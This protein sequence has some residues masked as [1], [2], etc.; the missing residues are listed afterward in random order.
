M[1]RIALTLLCLSSIR[2]LH[3][4]HPTVTQRFGSACSVDAVFRARS[5]TT[6]RLFADTEDKAASSATS[7]APVL[8]GKRVLPYKVLMAGLKGNSDVA[9]VFALMNKD[10]K[11]G[12]AGWE[13][14][15]HVGV[16]IDFE[17]DLTQLAEEFGPE[18]F[19]HV[20]ALSFMFP[21]EGAMQSIADDWRR[22][23]IKAGGK[24]NVDPVSAAMEMPYDVNDDDD[25]E[26][27]EDD[28]DFM[29]MT[30]EAMAMATGGGVAQSEKAGDG[31]VSPFEMPEAASVS[32]MAEEKVP[33][34]KENVDK[35]LDEVRPYLISDGGNVSVERVDEATR[36]VYL[37]L[38]GA[39]GSCPSS[40][41]TMQ[42]G[43]E[44]VLKEKFENLGEVLRV[45]DDK[46]KELSFEMV[47]AEVNRIS[48]AIMAMGGTVEIV[49]VDGT[50]GIVE[51]KFSG[52]SK[53][54]QGLE[55]AI[56]D[57]DFVTEVK[58][59]E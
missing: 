40:T 30:A 31:V 53:V 44:R 38:E 28:V 50:S 15:E 22:E 24:I 32:T 21:S 25:D 36:N 47:A 23:A 9:G 46:P 17:A 19:A 20:R 45:E 14:C 29:E 33:F 5:M 41:V 57:I 6:T 10:Y 8:D 43:I 11:R 58:F 56:R 12:C 2:L 52:A 55:L 35:V 7:T 59:L 42:M 18:K 49:S 16:S 4:F 51:I 1:I 39:C 54:R 27:D 3:G 37:K 48:P 34:N 13:Q 26:M